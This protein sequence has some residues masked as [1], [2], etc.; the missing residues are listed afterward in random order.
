MNVLR[1]TTGMHAAWPMARRHRMVAR[2]SILA[3]VSTSRMLSRVSS[4]NFRLDMSG[5]F[6]VTR[7]TSSGYV[8]TKKKKFH[9]HLGVDS[10]S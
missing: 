5:P 7:G 9:N 4:R 6:F 1:R 2:S 10:R 3:P 8:V